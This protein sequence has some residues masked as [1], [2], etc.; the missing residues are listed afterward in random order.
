[1][2]ESTLSRAI[3]IGAPAAAAAIL[4]PKRR[5]M[6]VAFM[7]GERSMAEVARSLGMP[8]NSLHHHVQAFVRQGLIAVTR[9]Q[10]RAGRPIRFYRAAGNAFLVPASAMR[11]R[12]GDALAAELRSALDEAERRSG[13]GDLLLFLD[14]EGRPRMERGQAEA[15]SDASE[16]WR[17]LHLDRRAARR[18]AREV[19]AVLARYDETSGPGAKPYLVHLAIAPRKPLGAGG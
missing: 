11:S 4:D 14:D 13:Y 16:L 5:R 8:I 17:V 2:K 19:K 10:R 18:L 1:M 15:P 9:E 12:P 3:R 6:L 7:A